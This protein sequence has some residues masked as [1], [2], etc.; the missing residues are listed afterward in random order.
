MLRITQGR[1]RGPGV[2]I[3]R[4]LAVLSPLALADRQQA[5]AFREGDIL[6]GQITEFLDPQ[7]GVEQEPDNG[8]VACL[9]R[10]FD[11]A[12]QGVLFA[13]AEPARPRPLL[14]D[15]PR[16]A[17]RAPLGGNWEAGSDARRGCPGQE[18]LQGGELAVDA[19]GLELPLLDQPA[20]ELPQVGRGDLGW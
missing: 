18:A 10:A 19:A 20:L 11:G 15:G 16:A 3:E 7:P 1:Q 8:Q 12:E 2:L 14:G 5:L 4:H 9:S 17:P 6:P 13:A